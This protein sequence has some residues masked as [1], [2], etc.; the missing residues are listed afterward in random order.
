MSKIASSEDLNTAIQIVHRKKPREKV[1]LRAAPRTILFPTAAQIEARIRFGEAASKA[2]DGKGL[3]EV[4][5]YGEL[6]QAAAKVVEELKGFKSEEKKEPPK[7]QWYERMLMQIDLY[8]RLREL[9]V[10]AS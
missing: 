2:K 3:V 6:P 5:G 8:E 4:E 1:Y 7:P 9:M 10:K